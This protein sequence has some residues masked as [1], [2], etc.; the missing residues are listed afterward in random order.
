MDK[1]CCILLLKT[2]EPRQGLEGTRTLAVSS[3]CRRALCGHVRGRRQER[4][5]LNLLH[6]MFANALRVT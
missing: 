2:E 6:G 5:P 1:W 4:A 3:S